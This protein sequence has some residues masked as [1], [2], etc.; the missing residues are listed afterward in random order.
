M[1]V[2]TDGLVLLTLCMCRCVCMSAG[3]KSMSDQSSTSFLRGSPT[4]PWNSCTLARLTGLYAPGIFLS[5]PPRHWDYGHMPPCLALY[6]GS[7]HSSNQATSPAP[8][9]PH[10]TSASQS[11]LKGLRSA[12]PQRLCT[13]TTNVCAFECFSLSLTEGLSCSLKIEI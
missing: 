3:Q 10:L 1:Y 8:R 12:R 13:H 5:P 6:L 9:W 2:P 7:Q 4:E 11:P